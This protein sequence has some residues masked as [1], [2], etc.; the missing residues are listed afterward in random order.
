MYEHEPI[1]N[2][3][4]A[5]LLMRIEQK[6]D[7]AVGDHEQRLRRLERNVYVASGVAMAGGTGFGALL[8]GWL[9]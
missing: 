1:T 7:A 8:S 9:S 6:L 5:R 4:L 2:A 3:E